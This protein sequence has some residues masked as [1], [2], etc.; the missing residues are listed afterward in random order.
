[1]VRSYFHSNPSATCMTPN[2]NPQIIRAIVHVLV[3][4]YVVR[5]S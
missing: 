5:A 1:M 3:K 4:I 2:S